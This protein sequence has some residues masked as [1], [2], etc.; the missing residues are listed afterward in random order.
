MNSVNNNNLPNSNTH[1]SIK[2][3]NGQNH[4][5]NL[6]QICFETDKEIEEFR[7]KLINNSIYA[8]SVKKV[9][10]NFSFEWIQSLPININN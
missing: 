10:P 7:K 1:S 5:D 9:K 4:T 2:A 3:K 6:Q 8:N